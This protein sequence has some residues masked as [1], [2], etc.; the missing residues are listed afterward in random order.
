[1]ISPAA[2][3]DTFTLFGYASFDADDPFASG[4]AGTAV[5]LTKVRLSQS[6]GSRTVD[7][8]GEK[9]ARQAILFLFSGITRADGALTLPTIEEGDRLVSGSHTTQPSSAEYQVWTVSG[10]KVLKAKSRIHHTEVS[11][12]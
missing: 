7:A 10:V 4:E 12:V 8:Q 11:L 9:S 1:M 5:V 2:L 6:S 3:C